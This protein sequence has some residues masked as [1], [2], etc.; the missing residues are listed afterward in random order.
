MENNEQNL[1]KSACSRELV[2]FFSR[3]ELECVE[4]LQN[5]ALWCAHAYTLCTWEERTGSCNMKMDKEG[6]GA[7]LVI[8]NTLNTAMSPTCTADIRGILNTGADG[9]Q[10]KHN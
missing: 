7:V 8:M 4:S 3:I 10:G 2:P 6:K 9:H 1:L 5:V